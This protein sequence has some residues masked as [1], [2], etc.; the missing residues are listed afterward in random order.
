MISLKQI[1]YALAVERSLHLRKAAEECAVSQSALGSA[2]AEMEK[3]LGFQ[4][5]ERDNRNV[6]TQMTTRIIIF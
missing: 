6:L 2:L 1:A 5:F 4:I 3:Q